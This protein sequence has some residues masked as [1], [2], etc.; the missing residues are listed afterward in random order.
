MRKA[1][2]SLLLLSS[3]HHRTSRYTCRYQTGPGAA[4]HAR[5]TW[6]MYN[7][8]GMHLTCHQL[9]KGWFS[10]CSCRA[11][12]QCGGASTA[13]A[14][15]AQRDAGKLQRHR[16]QR[17]AGFALASKHGLAVH[18]TRAV[19]MWVKGSIWNGPRKRWLGKYKK[20]VSQARGD[21]TVKR[22]LQQN[23]NVSTSQKITLPREKC[24]VS[25][26]VH[27]R[28]VFSTQPSQA[29]ITRNLH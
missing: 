6:T 20:L 28:H 8:L 10:G 2:G 14:W 1:R 12:R 29:F 17:R 13:M 27:Q 21:C 26:I 22:T 9:L 5:A 23:G 18:T 19:Q 4:R 15:T 16:E 25:A 24:V 7:G 3:C 11:R